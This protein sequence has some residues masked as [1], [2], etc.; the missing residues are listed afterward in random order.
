MGKCQSI[1]DD[2]IFGKDVFLAD[3]INL[4]G[5]SIGNNSR[6]GPFVEIQKGAHIGSDCKIQSHSFI[7][8][9]VYIKDRVFIGHGVIFINP[10]EFSLPDFLEIDRKPLVA[11]QHLNQRPH[12]CEVFERF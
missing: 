4:Y 12:H 7:C 10:V 1:A 11:L 9:G 2:V 5:C 3:F 6:I 8:E